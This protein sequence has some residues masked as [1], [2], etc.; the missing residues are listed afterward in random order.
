MKLL[1]TPRTGSLG[2]DTFFESRFGQCARQRTVPR[3]PPS[4]C[5]ADARSNFG[6]SSGE[7]GFKFTEDQRERWNTAALNAPSQPWK[8]Q[9]S[10]LSG[11]Q[12]AVQVNSTLR[13]IGQAPLLEPPAPVVFAPNPVT[14]LAIVNDPEAGTRLLLSVGTVTE[15]IMVF[16][17]PPCSAGRMKHRRVYYLGLQG[18]ATNGQCDITDLYTARF[19][20]PRP[21]QKVFIVTCQTRNGWK[22]Q[23]KVLSAIVPPLPPAGEQQSNEETKVTVPAATPKPES[24]SA[25]TKPVSLLSPAM[26]KGSTLEARREYKLQPG[27]HPLSILCAPLVHGVRMA[28]GRLR[29][30]AMKWAGA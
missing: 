2:P 1:A 12:F 9:Y 5:K 30:P 25:S 21:G 19:G 14:R 6:V 24:N 13:C 23:D 8:G 28:L 11:Q 18:P 26:Y 29:V 22:A 15:D 10:H 17:Q 16:G 3:D 7:Y 20:Q 27:V 4:N